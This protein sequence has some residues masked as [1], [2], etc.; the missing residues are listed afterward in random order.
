MHHCTLECLYAA[1]LSLMSIFCD[2]V[3][4]LSRSSPLFSTSSS[5]SSSSAGG[6]GDELLSLY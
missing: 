6:D 1:S 5:L 4:L 2:E 3:A